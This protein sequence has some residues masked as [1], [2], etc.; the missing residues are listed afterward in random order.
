MKEENAAYA[1]IRYDLDSDLAR[2]KAFD[3]VLASRDIASIDRWLAEIQGT[4]GTQSI[5]AAMASL[6]CMRDTRA[7]T[8]IN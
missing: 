5:L 3:R 2:S 6:P 4:V 8:P 7:R 1:A